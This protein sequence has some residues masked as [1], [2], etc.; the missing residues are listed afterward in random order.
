MKSISSAPQRRA[1]RQGI[2]HDAELQRVEIRQPLLEIVRVL[3]QDHML[4]GDPFL[5]YEGTGA[6]G[7]AQPVLAIGL[8]GFGRRHQDALVVAAE[9]DGQGTGGLLQPD[10]QCV[11]VHRLD[12]A[13]Y[14]HSRA[15]PTT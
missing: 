9:G 7:M 11:F 6:D 14:P 12:S 3:L 8:K 10:A 4:A 1:G 13:R 2:F 5:E 15:G